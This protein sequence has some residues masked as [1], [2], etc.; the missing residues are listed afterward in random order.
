MAD[1]L[2]IFGTT[3]TNVNGIKATDTGGTVLEFTHGGTS[4]YSDLENKPQ[5]N[6]VTLTGNKTLVELG[7]ASAQEL[8]E[9]GLY[10]DS[11]GDLCEVD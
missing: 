2:R 11:N 4:D 1:N 10:R 5:I 9:L 7:I 8:T 3:Y 6:S